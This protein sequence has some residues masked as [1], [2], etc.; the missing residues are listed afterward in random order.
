MTSNFIYSKLEIERSVVEMEKGRII[1][2]N[3]V[4]SSGKTSIVE[5]L[6]D[7]K[8]I[9]FYVVA[10]DLFQEMIGEHYLHENYWRYYIIFFSSYLKFD[11]Y[12]Y[13]KDNILRLI[14]KLL[15]PAK[16]FHIFLD[17]FCISLTDS[18][19]K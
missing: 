12:F 3:G 11:I 14:L 10:N 1:F 9:F 8:D 17:F 7:Q 4:T 15:Y 18:Y 5:A 16:T 19:C 2:L 6:Q 13:Q